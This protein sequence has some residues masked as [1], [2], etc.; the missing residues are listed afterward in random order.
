MSVNVTQAINELREH[1]VEFKTRRVKKTRPKRNGLS[2]LSSKKARVAFS[3]FPA[4][5]NIIYDTSLKFSGHMSN[6]QDDDYW[7]LENDPSDRIKVT[8]RHHRS[9]QF[10]FV[11]QRY[12][13]VTG[14]YF[15]IKKKG[16]SVN[17]LDQQ[18][19]WAC[20]L[21]RA[22]PDLKPFQWRSFM[23]VDG[24]Q[25]ESKLSVSSIRLVGVDRRFKL[26]DHV[27]TNDEASFLLGVNYSD[28]VP[29]SEREMF[30]Y[31]FVLFNGVSW[32]PVCEDLVRGAFQFVGKRRDRLQMSVIPRES[33]RQS[34][35]KKR[36]DNKYSEYDRPGQ[37]VVLS[38]HDLRMFKCEVQSKGYV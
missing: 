22:E 18:V 5:I 20:S 31:D 12:N 3:F 37:E 17:D 30:P 38:E 21:L 36:H 34:T 1:F 6:P 4:F 33:H 26:H 16:C 10:Q 7:Y 29:L 19:E 25:R 2:V 24:E 23:S 27:T 8:E 15:T 35:N 14:G 13:T 32:L 28:I 11:A 9:F